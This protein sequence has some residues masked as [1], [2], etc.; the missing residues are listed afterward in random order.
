MSPADA[1]ALRLRTNP[2]SSPAGWL[3]TALGVVGIVTVSLATALDMDGFLETGASW[4]RPLVT[5]PGHAL[6]LL[7]W[8]QL[9]PGWRR[10][11]VTL[12]I[13]SAALLAAPPLHSRDAW[14]YAAQGWLMNNGLDPY[15]VPSGD[16]GDAGLLVGIHWFET[17]S[18]YPPLSLEIFRAVSWLFGG[19]LWLS[20]VGMRL[21]NLVAMAVLAWCLPRLARRVGVASSTVLWA[22][23]LNPLVVIQWVGGIHND[24]VMVALVAVAFL[25]AHAPGWRGYRGMLAGGAVLGVAMLVKQS[26]AVAG[27]AVVALAWAAAAAGL[28]PRRRNWWALARR[29]VAAGLVAVAVFVLVSLATGLGFGW[30]N[31]TA[32]SPLEATSNSPISWVASFTRFHELLSDET[33]ITVFTTISSALILVATVWLLRRYGPHPPDD[34]GRPWVVAIGALLAFAL[35]GPATQP[36]YLT[37]AV[38]FVVLAHPRLRSQHLWL[39]VVCAASVIPALQDFMAPYYS[40]FLLAVP[41]WWLW[42]R[43]RRAATPVFP[44]PDQGLTSRGP[45]ADGRR[46]G[47]V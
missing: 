42:R 12:T 22:G 31:P 26:A 34:A 38:P 10:P 15:L 7:A 2:A 3:W 47:L 14:S 5:L 21:P 23:L 28:E 37:W 20:S 11:L 25:V 45:R 44:T 16:A 19:D 35:L 18:V 24:A 41:S 46:D 6:L 39:V 8:W 9:G 32:G 29:A 43:L 27:V 4:W 13:W 30:R 36:W 40:M 1:A 33:V 17:T